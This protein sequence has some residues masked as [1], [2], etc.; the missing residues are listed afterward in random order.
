M[1]CFL[2]T[3]HLFPH[4]TMSPGSR[5]FLAAGG[6]KE[7]GTSCPVSGAQRCRPGPGAPRREPRMALGR[8]SSNSSLIQ[9]LLGPGKCR[10]GSGHGVRGISQKSF[11][12]GA[13]PGASGGAA[14]RVCADLPRLQPLLLDSDTRVS[15]WA[16]GR[17]QRMPMRSAAPAA[18]L[19]GV[20]LRFQPSLFLVLVQRGCRAPLRKNRGVLH[21]WLDSNQDREHV[22]FLENSLTGLLRYVC[23]SLCLSILYY[24]ERK[25]QNA[26]FFS[27]LY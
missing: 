17:G 14:L 25:I 20:Q 18:A 9:R 13:S 27:P 26:S 11:I 15:R 10:L 1:V 6:G 4:P 5:R 23:L 12:L 21:H 16:E 2:P 7:P 22:S 24:S 19:L 8:E 3:H